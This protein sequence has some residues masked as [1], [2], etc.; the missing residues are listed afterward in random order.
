MDTFEL[1]NSTIITVPDAEGGI[2]GGVG[3]AEGADENNCL[4]C[5]DHPNDL[6]QLRCRHYY[7]LRCLKRWFRQKNTSELKCCYCSKSLRFLE[8]IMVM[9]MLHVFKQ[10]TII[11]L[12]I[13][14]SIILFLI[15]LIFIERL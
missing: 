2:G 15:F 14:Y 6:I 8:K 12:A 7:C 9:D 10:S 4:I 3:D 1:N 5:I 11:F 13:V